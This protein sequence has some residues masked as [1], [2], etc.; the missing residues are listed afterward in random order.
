VKNRWLK[1]EESEFLIPHT[2]K[3]RSVAKF[4]EDDVETLKTFCR[5]RGIKYRDDFT[6]M[7]REFL[8][9]HP[10]VEL[11]YRVKFATKLDSKQQNSRSVKNKDK[12]LVL[13][14]DDNFDKSEAHRRRL[15]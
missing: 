9:L 11:V 1:R 3:I 8:N 12:K 10:G 13:K 6:E 14:Q 2:T 7:T 15:G 5:A 4:E